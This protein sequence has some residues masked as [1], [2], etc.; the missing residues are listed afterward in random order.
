MVEN[1]ISGASTNGKSTFTH[2][3][4]QV[5]I[6][7]SDQV[8]SVHLQNLMVRWSERK[9]GEVEVENR[10]RGNRH[11]FVCNIYT[12]QTRRYTAMYIQK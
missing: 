2:R 5:G 7:S 1:A 10:V 3:D 4:K 8:E 6:F 11:F 9:M 12:C